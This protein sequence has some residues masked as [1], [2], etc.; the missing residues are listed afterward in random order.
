MIAEELEANKCKTSCR[1]EEKHCAK[2]AKKSRIQKTTENSKGCS[3]ITPWIQGLGNNAEHQYPQQVPFIITKI[4]ELVDSGEISEVIDGGGLLALFRAVGLNVH[5]DT[6]INVEKDGKFV[7]LS[8][9]LNTVKKAA[10]AAEESSLVKVLNSLW[11]HALQNI[12]T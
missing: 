8:E 6:K 7:S 5:M 3:N 10:N 4:A 1:D 12:L 11:R 2:R 9:K